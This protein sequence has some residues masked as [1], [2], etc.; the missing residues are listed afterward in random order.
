SLSKTVKDL[1]ASSERLQKYVDTYKIQLQRQF[2]TMES[3]IS[4]YNSIGTF[5]N[6]S[7]SAANGSNNK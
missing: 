6:N 4:K 3:L 2:S 1:Q 7:A 5:L